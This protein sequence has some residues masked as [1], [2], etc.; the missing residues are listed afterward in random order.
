MLHNNPTEFLNY[1]DKVHQRTMNVVRAIS[2]DKVDWRFRAD[3]FTLG[4]VV[5]HIAASNRYIF[6]EV[7]RSGRSTY[8]GCGPELAATYDEIVAFSERMHAECVDI[9]SSL[10]D[11]DW[12]RKNPT[13]AGA[14]VTAWKWLRSMLEHEIHHRGQI[15][16]YLSLLE[17]AAPPIY[18][19]TSEQV[20]ERSAPQ[21]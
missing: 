13:P 11:E 21:G 4:D 8:A 5:R 3:K 7:V 20:R 17:V 16:I 18:G 10:N 12:N 2:P 19:L 6:A 9:F 14:P 15:Y 1:F